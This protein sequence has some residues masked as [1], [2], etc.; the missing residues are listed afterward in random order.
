MRKPGGYGVWTQADGQQKEIDS[1][2]CCHCNRVVFVPPRADPSQLGGFCM[3][4]HKHI[5]SHCAD[6]GRCIPLMKQIEAVEDRDR[7]RRSLLL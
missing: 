7:F 5:C 6:D 1:F 3:C 2:S 4:C